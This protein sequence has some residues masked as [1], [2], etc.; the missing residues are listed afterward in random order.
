[1]ANLTRLQIKDYVRQKLGELDSQ[2]I[3]DLLLNA[4]VNF[5]VR[6]VQR[7]L[8]GIGF[9]YFTK[10]SYNNN[11][12]FSVPSDMLSYSDSIIDLKTSTGIKSTAWWT[13]IGTLPMTDCEAYVTILEPGIAGDNWTVTFDG[14]IALNI[15][16]SVSTKTVTI[17]WSNGGTL[18]S[19]LQD[20]INANP[21]LNSIMKIELR[22]ADGVLTETTP[23]TSVL[24][25][26]GDGTGWVTAE[27]VPIRKFNRSTGTYNTPSTTAPIYVRR[28]DNY[29]NQLVE[30]SPNSITCSVMNYYYRL[31]DLTADTDSITIP[32]E[33]EE[34]LSMDLLVKQYE[35]L[36]NLTSS[37]E[38]ELDYQTKMAQL[39]TKYINKLQL[40]TTEKN[41]T[42]NNDV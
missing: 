23:I 35:T 22:G 9:K 31:P 28:G 26:G 18:M 29:D 39:E 12:I 10:Q 19:A 17:Q 36:K 20:Y 42:E 25:D 2:Q 41:R 5:S 27:E 15:I 33:F 6:K 13:K 7:D 1:M 16:V 32:Q 4:D 21:L 3:T 34:L 40:I 24:T 30:I 37:K 8:M 11:H 38:K 14:N